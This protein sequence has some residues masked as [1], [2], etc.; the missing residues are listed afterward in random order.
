MWWFQAAEGG[1]F[2]GENRI[3]EHYVQFNN[4]AMT[5]VT[6]LWEHFKNATLDIFSNSY[7]Q[8]SSIVEYWKKK[9]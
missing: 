7:R 6:R 9:S 3:A 8:I 1:R 5:Q 4:D 2:Q